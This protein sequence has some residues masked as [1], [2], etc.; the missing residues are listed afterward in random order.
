MKNQFPILVMRDSGSEFMLIKM[1]LGKKGLSP[2][3]AISLLLVITVAAVTLL[4]NYLVP[5][6]RE[7]LEEGSECLD[8]SHYFTIEENLFEKNLNCKQGEYYGVTI[9]SKEGNALAEKV[10]GISFDMIGKNDNIILNRFEDD[11]E[12][13]SGTSV[14]LYPNRCNPT[15]PLKIPKDG[16]VLT[17]VIF[18]DENS[19]NPWKGVRIRPIIDTTGRTRICEEKE[20]INYVICEPGVKLGGP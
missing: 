6:V 13:C 14:S 2:V 9:K 11:L 19:N 12:D 4:A 5:F 20:S 16:N 3:V 8:Y 10:L 7:S 18:N 15:N 1:I 17:F